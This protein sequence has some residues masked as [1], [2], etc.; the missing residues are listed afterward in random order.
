MK[1]GSCA[2]ITEKG[3]KIIAE[4]L[5]M[6]VVNINKTVIE[7]YEKIIEREWMNVKLTSTEDISSGRGYRKEAK[8]YKRRYCVVH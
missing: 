5:V 3:A 4:K 7:K 8:N 1:R 2:F 6:K